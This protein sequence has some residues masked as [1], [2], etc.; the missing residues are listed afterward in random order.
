MDPNKT[1]DESAVTPHAPRFPEEE[2]ESLQKRGAPLPLAPHP[3][4]HVFSMRM[5][6][7]K[8]LP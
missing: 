2:M 4:L 1:A 8:G 6:L 5:P 7:H 3:C